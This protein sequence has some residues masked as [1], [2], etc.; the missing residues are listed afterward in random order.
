MG[1]IKALLDFEKIVQE[2]VKYS[3]VEREIGIDVDSLKID[4]SSITEETTTSS[5]SGV[6]YHEDE[7]DD[8]ELPLTPRRVIEL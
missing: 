8:G 2:M 4:V 5:S 6:W 3:E 7:K 1:S